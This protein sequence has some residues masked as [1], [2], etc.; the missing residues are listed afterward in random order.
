MSIPGDSR[1]CIFKEGSGLGLVP[2]LLFT[3]AKGKNTR[4]AFFAVRQPGVRIKSTK[5]ND[6]RGGRISVN[7]DL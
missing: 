6:N 1:T 7:R 3:C 4:Q 2:K 5:H